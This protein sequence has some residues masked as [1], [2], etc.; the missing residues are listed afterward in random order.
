[1]VETMI[2]TMIGNVD[3]GGTET[4]TV[5]EIG[6]GTGRETEIVIVSEMKRIMVVIGIGNGTGKVEIGRGGTG[7]VAVGVL[8]GAEAGV[9]IAGIGM[10]GITARD[11]P[12]VA[13]APEDGMDLRTMAL[14][15]SRRKRKKRRRRRM[16]ERTIR[17]QKLLKPTGSGHLWV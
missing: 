16:M 17:I 2:G 10:V 3:V 4:G 14:G 9:G 12:A 8:Q 5:T 6:I 7:T 11:M 13:S 1:M 15:K